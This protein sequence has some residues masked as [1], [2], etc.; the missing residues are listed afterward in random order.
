MCLLRVVWFN[1]P[2]GYWMFFWRSGQVGS[3]WCDIDLARHL[4][5][6]PWFD[7]TMHDEDVPL[8]L[9][10]SALRI[11]PLWLLVSDGAAMCAL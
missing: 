4:T 5:L 8:A 2:L 10:R 7:H 1:H 11:Q 3:A 9:Q 6:S